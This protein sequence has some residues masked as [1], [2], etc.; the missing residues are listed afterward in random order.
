MRVRL[1][2]GLLLAITAIFAWGLGWIA[3]G[4]LQAGGVIGWGLGLAVV[5]L[6]V[7]T[8][9]VLWREVLFGLASARLSR[10]YA[11]PWPQGVTPAEEFAAART[12]IEQTEA[13]GDSPDWRAWYRL[14]VAYDA[15]RDR[16]QARACVRRAI[17]MERPT[18]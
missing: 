17:A 9:W 2:V 12:A 3:W 11:R 1:F 8:V 13:A 7:I 15:N 16:T 18:R 5:A 10:L 4:F 6:L 14:G